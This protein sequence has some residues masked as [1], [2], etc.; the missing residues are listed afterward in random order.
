MKM[1]NL[2]VAAAAWGVVTST[3][4]AAMS[5][6][7]LLED[8]GSFMAGGTVVTAPG[9]YDGSKATNLAGQTLHGDHAYVF[10]QKP[11]NAHKYGIVFLHGLGQSGKTWE[12]TPDGRD[13][14][15]NIFLEK[16]YKTYV[17]DQPRRGKASQS[18]VPADLKATPQDQLWFNT[19]RLG[20]WPNYYKNAAVPRDKESL[21]QF[22]RQLTP[23]TGALDPKLVADDMVAIFDKVGDNILV[24]HSAGGGPGW[25]TAMRSSHVKAIIA[26]EPG[27]YFPFPE[28]E[29]PAVEPT[30]S[31][32]PAPGREVKKEDF[33][34]LT[35]I[36]IVIFYGDNIPSGNTPLA[37]WGQD[38]WRV[39]MNLAKKWEQVM[40]KYGGDV[41]VISLP[42]IGIKGNTHLLMSDLNNRDV[43][44]AMEKWM[45]KKGLVK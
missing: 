33:L 10:Y 6:P 26:L 31:A 15:Q 23:D 28:G 4:F 38:N 19:F 40:K 8:Q 39:R 16:G 25:E 32:F 34:K 37:D 30:S 14:F 2:L 35:K 42:D 17:V 11:A 29:L 1:K 44:D 41:E 13:G 22:F 9:T 12:T 24:T 20:Q 21:N 3:A 18:T 27:T 7:V 36:P 43:A 5:H 45:K